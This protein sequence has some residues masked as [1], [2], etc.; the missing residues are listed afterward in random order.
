MK[1]NGQIPYAI[2]GYG[3]WSNFPF[4]PSDLSPWLFWAVS[5]YVCATRD[6]AF[7][8][9]FHPYYN[10]GEATPSMKQSMAVIDSRLPRVVVT[11][12]IRLQSDAS[13]S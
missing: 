12:N 5:E 4:E 13:E 10:G 1:Q 8:D 3:S 7:L 9:E 2:A 6:F 11:S